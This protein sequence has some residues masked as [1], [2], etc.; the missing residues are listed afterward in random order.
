V[1]VPP[2]P[3]SL[4]TN[5]KVDETLTAKLE[6]HRSLNSTLLPSLICNI[7]L[8]LM[9]RPFALSPCGH[10]ACFSCLVNWFTSDA[11][12]QQQNNAEQVAVNFDNPSQNNDPPVAQANA[13][14]VAIAAPAPAPPIA[15]PPFPV[16][17]RKK[18]CPQCRAIV[19][20]RPIE[21]WLIKDMVGNVVRSGLADPDSIPPD[22]R[23]PPTA[24][25][26]TPARND[27]EWK[28]IFP[29]NANQQDLEHI[30]LTESLGI[31]DEED[32]G[33]YRCVNC[34]H[35]IVDGECCE[36]GRIYPGYHQGFGWEDNSDEDDMDDDLGFMMGLHPNLRYLDGDDVDFHT[37]VHVAWTEDERDE[38]SENS[39][40]EE[41]GYESSFIDDDAD[42]RNHSDDILEENDGDLTGEV[43]SGHRADPVVI[44][45][46][47]ESD[48]DD[49]HILRR[50][51]RLKQHIVVDDTS[52]ESDGDIAHIPE[53]RSRRKRPT[54]AKPPVDADEESD[55]DDALIP[56]RS[57]RLNSHIVIKS[58]EDADEDREEDSFDSSR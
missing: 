43:R 24:K 42:E 52:E 53:P 21:V 55:E 50:S 8:Y 44:S 16:P 41:E 3:A 36:C 17:R 12:G 22:L 9:H 54:S 30:F 4:P 34:M 10:V 38:L 7:C 46:D 32:G 49:P 20:S 40:S 6:A 2:T 57:A 48:E 45:S 56:R 25:T 19:R 23:N 51:S 5:S 11:P 15:V 58:D 37:P 1:G 31:R 35:E 18:T 13:N 26:P 47:E 27:E 29:T 33:V 39:G 14:E 28:D